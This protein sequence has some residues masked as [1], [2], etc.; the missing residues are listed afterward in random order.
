P[1]GAFPELAK[2]N[3]ATDSAQ[4][5]GTD[6]G[7]LQFSFDAGAE[8]DTIAFDGTAMKGTI[9]LPTRDLATRGITAKLDYLH[10]PEPPEPKETSGPPPPPSPPPASSP[11]APA[12]VP[13]L[14]V[15]IGDLRLGK[16]QLG[17]TAF[18]SASTP[19]G[20]RIEK[21]DSQGADFMIQSHGDWIGTKASSASHLVIDIAS[22]DFGK[23]LGAFG[24]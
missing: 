19:Q 23:M 22:H 7:M 8:N 4:V 5:F 20:M 3:I 16:A 18:E 13:P 14:H 10:W 11:I 9:E 24:F 6:L 21:F 15:T 2:A 17:T 1:G 12:A